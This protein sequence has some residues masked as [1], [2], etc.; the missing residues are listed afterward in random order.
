[1]NNREKLQK[2]SIRKYTVGTFSTVIATLVF[3]G[4]N[5]SHAQAD[6]LSETV[7]SPQQILHQKD[8]VNDDSKSN[9]N[10]SLANQ[11]DNDKTNEGTITSEQ[12]SKETTMSQ[13]DKES[14][15]NQITENVSTDTKNSIQTTDQTA[16][17]NHS[18]DLEQNNHTNDAVVNKAK[19]KLTAHVNNVKHSSIQQESELKQPAKINKDSLQA[20][21]DA[22]YHDYRFIDRDKVDQPTLDQVKNAFDKVNTLLGSNKPISDKSLQLAYQDLEQAVAT[23][24]T[25]PKRQ[26]QIRLDHQIQERAADSKSSDSY[27]SAITSYYVDNPNDGSG[28]PE[29]TYIYAA[30]KG[31]PFYLPNTPWIPL[32]ASDSKGIAYVTT[33]RL[34]DGYEWTIKFNQSHRMHEHMVFWFGLPDP[35]VP[36]GPVRFTIENPDNSNKVS[37][38]GVG[39]EEGLSL[40]FMWRTAGGIDSSRASNFVQG[41]RTGYTFYDEPTIHINSFKE[42]ARAPEFQHE[43]NASDDAKTNG[44]QNFALLNGEFPNQIYGIDRLYAF[45]GKGNASYTLQFKTQGSTAE[46]FYYAAGGRALEYRQLFS[47]NELYVE[48]LE[49]FTERV[50]NLTEVINRTYH[51][52]NSKNVYDLNAR[53]EVTKY[54]LDS[55]NENSEDFAS[56]PMSYAKKPS[57]YVGGFYNP[58]LPNNRFRGPGVAPLNEFEI[59]KLINNDTL[60]NAS[61]TGNPIKLNLGFDIQDG[62]GN[63]ETLMPVY[64]Y[65][66]PELQNNIGFFSNNNP[67]NRAELP[68]SKSAGHP[69]FNVFQGNMGNSYTSSG[70]TSNYV[71]PLRIQISSNEEFTDND[72]EITGV[73]SSLRI[74]NAAGRTNNNRER[75]LEL[76]GNIAPGDYLGTVRLRKKEQPFEIRVKPL[77]P[78]IDTTVR[79]LRGKGG[80]TPTITV[81]NVPAD[82][83][84]LVYLVV[85]GNLA[86]DGTNDPASVPRN[87]DIIASAAPSSTSNSVTFNQGDYVQNLP[88]TGVIRAIVY[89]NDNVISNFS[90]AVEIQADNTP[91]TIGNPLGLKNKYY[92]GDQV[93]FTIDITDGSNGTGIKSTNVSRLPQGWT[94][95]FVQ[96]ANGEGG[97]LRITG[98]V[99]DNQPFNSQIRFNV[100]ATDNNNNTTNNRQSKQIAINI[101]QMS[102]DFSPIVLPN[103]QKINVVNPGELTRT[104]ERDVINALKAVNTNIIPYLE[105]SSPINIPSTEMISF[106]YK[107]GS[108]D[109]ISISNAITYEPVRKAIYA[110]GNNTKEATVTIAR[111]QQFEFGDLKQYFALSNGADLPDSSLFTITAV[112]SLPNSAQ[113]SQLGVGTYTYRLNASDAYRQDQAPLTLKL[114]VVDVNQPTG[115]QRVY[116]ISTFNVTDDEK[117]QIK[118]AFIN[119]NRNQLQLTDNNIVITNTS[120]GTNTSTIT[121]NVIKDKLQK[122]FT[123]NATNMNFL[124]WVNFPNDYTV[125]WTSQTI[126]GRQTDGGFQWSQDHKS[127]IYRYDATS[128]RTI[129]ANDVLKLITANTTIPGLRTNIRGTEKALAEA[130]GTPS[131]NSVGY[132]LTAPDAAGQREFTYN[133][134]IIQ[135]LDLVETSHGYGGQPITYSN[136]SSN[137]TN[138]S[139]TNVNESAKNGVPAFTIDH[140][141]K[142]NTITGNNSPVYRAQLF[143]SPYGPPAYLQAI[144]SNQA[145]TTDVINVYF[146]P[147][148]SV[149]PT[150][151]LGNYNNHVV[152]SGESFTNSVAANDNYALGS[153]QV[154]PNSQVNG[155]VSNN[156]QTVTL[157]APNVTS[158]NDKT[159]TLVATDTSGNTT[160]QSFNV[161]VK[162]LK[163]KYRVTTN[164]TVGNPIR[165]ANI[166]DNAA[167][168]QA[169]QQKIIDS[170][171]TTNIAGTR[172]YATSGANEIRSKVVTGNVGRSNQ[173]PVATVTVTYADGSTSTVTVPVKHIIYNVVASPRYTIQGQDFPNGKGASPNDF[174]TLEN[175]DP[176]PDATITWL[177]NN[178]PN[179]NNTRIG[180]SI[181]VRANILFDGETTPIIKESSYMVVRTIPKQVFVTSRVTPIPGIDNPNNPKDYLKPINHSWDNNQQNMSFSFVG[182][183]SM[184]P[185]L[186]LVG[187]QTRVVRVT[188][189]NGQSENVR[190]LVNIRP[191][192]PRI[193]SNTVL[194]KAGLTNQDIKINNVLNQS[195]VTLFK[196]DGTPL[197][198]SN[199]TYG[200]GHSA[201]VVVSDA[202]PDGEIKAKTSLFTRNITY[203]TQN[204]QGQVQDVTQDITVDSFDS[205]PVR[206]TPQLHAIPDGAHFIKDDT[207][208]DFSSAARYIDQLPQGATAVWQDNADNWKN[209]VGNFT[210]TAVVTLPNGQG[211]RNVDIPVKI[212]PVAHAKAST[213]EVQGG[214]LSQGT[215]AINYITFDPNTNTN[216]ITA[217][218]ANQT[219]PS[220]S[221]PGVQNLTVNV[222]YPGVTTPVQV[223]VSLNVY[224]FNFSPNEYTTTI[225]TTFAR[226][227]E[228]SQYQHIVNNSGLPTE[229]FTYRWNQATTGTNGESWNALNKPS[230]AQVLNA[231]YDVLYNG[232]PFAT[233]QPARFII[234][235]VQ[236]SVPQ[237]SESKQGVITI[238][239]GANQSINTRTG[240][241]DTYADRLVIKHNGQVITTFVRNNSTSPWTKEASAQSVNGVVGSANGITIAPGTF[242]PSDNIQV[243][244]TQGNGELISD[245]QPSQMFTVVAPQPN[246]A[247]SHIWE[248]GQVEIAPNN[249]PTNLVNPTTALEITYIEQVGNTNEQTKTLQV[250]KGSNGQWSIADKPGY[251]TL[252]SATGK[253]TFNANTIKPNSDVTMISKAGTGNA[254]STNTNTYNIPN[255]HTV[256]INQIVKDFGTNVT[257]EDINNAVQA[258]NKHNATIKQG[259]PLP[260]N[261]AGGSTTTIPV[262][263]TYDDG[264]TEQITE[265]IFTKSDKRDLISAVNHL[266]DPISTDGKTPASITEFNN[267]MTNAQNEINTAMTQAEQVIQDQ[268]ASPEQVTQALNTVQAAQAKIDQAKALL[269]NKADNHELVQAKN[270]LQT[271]IDQQPSLDGMTQQSIDNYNAKRQAAQ[272]EITKAQQVIDNGDATPQQ[273]ATQKQNVEN[274]LNALN[275]A[276]SDLTADTSALQQAVQQL[277]RTGTTTGMRPASI[278]A[279]N[280]AMQ[281]LNPDLT[282]ARQNANAIINKPIRTVQEVQDALRQVNQVNE[283]ITQA[284]NQLQPLANNSELKTAKAKL[285]DE[286]NQTVSTDGMT[287]E[288]INAYQQAKQAAQTES[289]AAQQVINNGD[290]T[291]QDI[292]NEKAKVEDKY[293]ALKQTIA[294]LTP[295]VSPLE[296]AKV[297]LE[298]DINQATSTTGMTDQSVAN[299]NEKL[300]AA[301]QQLQEINQVLQSHPNV[302]TIRDYVAHANDA[303]SAL[304][305]ARNGLTVD[306][307]PLE[308]AKN[309]LQQSIDQATD[310]TGM[311]PDTINAYQAK[312]NAAKE[313]LSTINQVLNSNPTVDQINTNTTAANDA[314]TEL[315]DARS[316]LTPDQAPL[317]QAKIE[318]QDAINEAQSTDTTGMTQDSINALNE[319]LNAAKEN[320][321]EID[322]VLNNHPTVAQINDSVNQ[323]TNTKD[324]LNEARQNLVP[325]KA[326]LEAAKNALQQSINQPTNTTGMTQSSVDAYNEKLEQAKAKLASITQVL[327]GSPSVADINS[328]TNEAN[329]AKDALNQARQQLTVDKAPL[330]QAKTELEQSINQPTD[331]NGMTQESVAN[332][333]DKLNVAREKLREIEQVLNGNPTVDDINANTNAANNVTNALNQA[334]QQLTVD[335]A[336]LEAAKDALQQSINTAN[337]TDTNGMTQD[338]INTFNDKL[339]AAKEKLEAIKQVL[340]GNPTVQDI[341]TNVAQANSVKSDLDQAQSHLTPDKAPLEAAKNS[342]EASINQPTDTDGMTAAS[343]EAYHQELGKARQTLNESNQ[344]IAGQPT[345]AEIKA[346]VAQAQT[347]EADLNQAR[348]NL[349]LDRQPTLTTLQNATSLNDAQRN[350]LEEQ[351]NAAPNHA[352]L[353]ALQNDINQLNNAMT[354]LRDSIADNDQIKTGINYIDATPSIKSSYDNAVDDA[355]GTIDSQTQPITDP[356]TINQQAEAV[357]SSQA[358]LDGQQNL[359]R[360]KDEATATIVGAS[361]LN[362]AQKNALIQQ[363]SKAQNVQQANDI[364]QNADD[365]NNTMTALKQGIANHDQLI[366]SDNYVNA[367]PELKTAYNNKYD[368]AKAIV[369]GTGQSPILTSNEVNHA[370]K[371]VTFAA[372][373]LN[374]NTNLNNAKQQALTALGQLTHL[375]QAQRQALETQINDAHQ[376]DTV[377]NAKELA[378]NIDGAMANLQ[379][380]V[381]NKEDVKQG[382]DYIDAEQQKQLNYNDAVTNAE[383]IIN[384]TSQPTLDVNTI[385]QATNNV[386]QTK[387]A[388]D[389]EERLDQAKTAATTALDGLSHLNQAQKASLTDNINHA[390]RIADIEQLTQTA[391]DLNQ[392]MSDLQNGINNETTVLNSQ[393]YQ[394]ASPDNKANYTTAV[395]AAKDILNQAG[396]NKNKAQVEEALRQV[397]NAE[398]ALNGTQNLEQAKQDAKQQ[399]NSLT[400]LTDA[401]KAQLTHD[402]DHGQTVSDV[403]SIQNNA[404]TLNQAMDTLR[405]S[406]ADQTTVKDNEDYHDASP[407]QQQAY[408]SAVTDAENIINAATNPEMNA[409][410]INS[411]AQQVI[412]AKTKLNGDENLEA[413]KQDAKQYLD[414]LGQ[415]TDQQKA[416]L[417]N[418]ISQ[419]P[420]ISDVNQVKQMAN[421]LNQAMQQLQ[422]EVNQAP[423]VKTTENYTDADQSKQSDYD[424][425]VTTAE[426]ILDQTNGPNTSQDKVEEALQRIVAAKKALNGDQKLND[427][428]TNAQQYLGTLTHL[429]DAQRQAFETNINQANH[430]ADVNQIKQEAQ[431]LDGAMDQLNTLVN[432]QPSVQA[433]QNYLDA[434]QS[435]QSDYDM[436]LDTAQGIVNQQSGPNTPMNEV[437]NLINQI[438]QAQQALNGELNLEDAKRNATNTI[439]NSPDLNDAQKDALKAQV[440]N[441]KRV[442]DV[443]AI[444]QLAT[445]LNNNMTSLKEAIADKNDTLTSGNYINASD[446]K[447]QAYTN[448]VDNAEAI[449][450]GA[451]GAVLIPSEISNATSQVNAAKQDLNGDENLREAKQ[452][453]T[454]AV[455]GLASLNDAQRDQLKQQISQAQTLPDIATTQNKATVLNDAMHTLRDSIANASNIKTS[456][457]YT[458][459]NQNLQDAYNSQVDNANGIINPIATPTMDP[460]AITQAATQ[461]TTAEKALNGTENLRHAQQDALTH[462]DNLSHLTDAQKADFTQQINQATHVS[463]VTATQN[464]ANDLNTAMDQLNQ[465]IANQQAIKQSVNYTDANTNLKEDYSNAI[466]E[467]QQIL[468]KAHGPNT[469]QTDVVAAMQKVQ[470]AEQALNGN[471]NVEHAKTQALADLEHLTS[472]N[473]AQKE[474]LTQQINDATTVADVNQQSDKATELNTAMVQLQDG[475][476]NKQQTLDS[477]NYIDAE[478]SKQQAYN[479]AVSTAEQLLDKEHG[480]NLDKDAVAQALAQVTSTK[481]ALDGT[482]ILEQAK[483]NATNAIN[484]LQ[485]LT[486]LQKDELKRQIQQ[487]QNVANVDN[488]KTQSQTLDQAMEALRQSIQDNPSIKTGQNYL[489]ASNSNQNDYNTAIDQA[490]AII[491]ATSQPNMSA[492]EINQA[493]TKVNETKAALNGAQNLIQAKETAKH[494]I[495]QMNHLNQNQINALNDQVQQAN[496]IAAVNALKDS[497]TSLNTVMGQLK[498]TIAN[499]ND[500]QQS[501]NYTDA[502]TDKQQAYDNAVTQ[503]EAITDPTNGTNATQSQ[504]EAAIAKVKAAQQDLNGNRKVEEAKATAKQALSTYANL[505]HAQVNTATQ[506]INDAQTLEAVTQAQQE[507]NTL[508]NAMGQLQQGIAH[509][510]DVEQSVDYTDADTDKQQAYTDAVTQ[511]QSILD[512]DHGN[513]LTQSQVEQALANVNQ[514]QHDLNG[515]EKVQ[516]A[517]TAAIQDLGTYSNLNHAQTNTAQDRINNAQ[518]LA[519]VAQAKQTAQNL[520]HAMR[521]L[522]QSI[523]NYQDVEQSVDY[524]DADTNKQSA[525]SNAVHQ[526]QNTLDKDLGHDLT[527]SEVEQAIENVNHAKQ[528]LNGEEKVSEAKTDALQTLNNDTQ[529]N[530]HQREAAKNEINGA[531]TL[532]QVAQALDQATALNTAMGQLKDSISDQASIKQQINYTDADTD[533]KTNYDDAVTNAQVILDPV[534]GNNLSKEQVESAI[535]QVNT[536]KDQLNGDTNLQNAKNEA[537]TQLNAL[538]HINHAQSDNLRDQIATAPSVQAVH[539]IEATAQALDQAMQQLQQSIANRNDI[540]NSQNYADASPDKK[541]AYDQALQNADDI[542]AKTT[543]PNSNQQAVEQAMQAVTNAA[544]EL[545]GA[546]NLHDAQSQATQAI[547]NAPH[548]NEQQKM[549]LKKKVNQAQTVAA[550]TDLQNN[551]DALNTA[552]EQLKQAIADHDTIV[553]DGNYTNASPQEQG[554][555]TDAYQRAQNLINGTPDVIINPADITTATQNVN[556]AEQGLNGNT[557][558]A[559]AKQEATN[560]LQQM[561]GLSDAQR[562]SIQDQI[563]TA[564]QLPDVDKIK[565]NAGNLN[566]AMSDLRQEVAKQ[567]DVQASQ[568]YVDANTSNQDDYNHAITNAESMI[569]E[570]TQPTL[571][572]EAVTQALNQIKTSTQDLNGVENLNNAKQIATNDLQHL[573]HLNQAQQA[574][575]TQQLKDAPNVA[576]VEQ[577]KAKATSLDQ[578]MEQLINA[579]NDKDQVHQ[580]VN[581]SDAD[582]PKQSAYD[583]A[584]ND[585]QL[586]TDPTTGSNSSQAEVEVALSAINTAKQDLNGNRKVEDAKNN[587]N[588]ALHSL[589]HLNNAQR[590][591]IEHQ[592]DQAQTLADIDRI[593]NDAQALNN[594]MEQLAD[595]LN[596]K[597]E[598]L[599][600]QNYNDA[601]PDKKTD[602][603]DAVSNAET[604]LNPTQGGNLTKDEVEAAINAVN[605]K[606]KRP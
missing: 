58:S 356:T 121:V 400:S 112:N 13:T 85:T 30:N 566:N 533:R 202:L 421:D 254:E 407:D 42:F 50:K 428:K 256:T 447:R 233:S 520:N 529:L 98:I 603:T 108:T 375:N 600:S 402:I 363:V 316:N 549:N 29:G 287:T 394:D 548:L 355:K 457:N 150:L 429:T 113:V 46:R 251:V 374:G 236:P 456:Q 517:K 445:E 474:A 436:Y 156:N 605:S 485:N 166:R 249:T 56:D 261:L 205:D 313:K 173:S 174:F 282:Q 546:Q 494:D 604:I 377:N 466:Q 515:D 340:N 378:T 237:I 59:Y 354:K 223:P 602:Y 366:Q 238:A 268:F 276:K 72:W 110:E 32:R 151:S 329:I 455:D 357:K 9:I 92:K 493:A 137:K 362:Q 305:T 302:A 409:D 586:I 227:I 200:P 277:D 391:N 65:V 516:E 6:E 242:S 398:Q 504:V 265:T 498:D 209:N 396:P 328:N 274:A 585:A 572:P 285:D 599:N 426:A 235:N 294:N 532:S 525:Y 138:S 211:T 179:K 160:N 597:A 26:S 433:T 241:I 502:D 339:N 379:Q 148:D 469:S 75:N 422:A 107:D 25:L 314:K 310:T 434:D 562:Q 461:V 103:V 203:T 273:I 552:M 224:Q 480:Q 304:D 217:D 263:I 296:R 381:A 496:D 459:A 95:Q 159:I 152:Y 186:H 343:L 437:Q 441:G 554:A 508:N 527:Q 73:P 497:A 104:E 243:I 267:A 38:L 479:Q 281:A 55:N 131:Y 21:F 538:D 172:P 126:P 145:N 414:T 259:T 47:Y 283:R 290:A 193:D 448:Q 33:K 219:L 89:Y 592:I 408:N 258:L 397:Q 182:S 590:E 43:Q 194:F 514:A 122:S 218:W 163:D 143:L 342:L 8:E 57:R 97:T 220:T 178:T 371:Q 199:T 231:K 11:L 15:D 266:D 330:Q 453:A 365:L 171:T 106:N 506:H 579:V 373:A 593:N 195:P 369:E 372:Q 165:I 594:A 315:D 509:H 574:D 526:A 524:T 575:L 425:S 415:I 83:N 27:Q 584:I 62:Y 135:A 298:N 36:V 225:G 382:E 345:V 347:N 3:L 578:A 587:A 288:S 452:N 146:V 312:L 420:H 214:Q 595:S 317:Q 18:N 555:Y 306:K 513:D 537:N 311:T 463:D 309:A 440:S 385:N 353:V 380:S 320:I 352:A 491:D 364:K 547:E 86:Q 64:L 573:S 40:P 180:E 54:I 284:I 128:G 349:T 71:Q 332:Y 507:A 484:D 591:N 197:A 406:I 560:A 74:E 67:N 331:T 158:S 94:S 465:A 234:R 577:V 335:K 39:T 431:S 133:G 204:N 130:G 248:N 601:S 505:N 153:V 61:R 341:N 120:N 326:P 557:N 198:I 534:N 228:A 80:T 157:H 370:L 450:N 384:E 553:A 101:G 271:S 22:N 438:N 105:N 581:Y 473:N 582:Q 141:I 286:I 323:A 322:R 383:T 60:T 541:Q 361:D 606:K 68:E 239:P 84:A 125:G 337:N 255:A 124:R 201:T 149:N 458:D 522:Q 551:A 31:K 319:K 155:T 116:R 79:E 1:M 511:A 240:N 545:N 4:F 190:F 580:S 523:D 250:V 70:N 542:L 24:R 359:Q 78:Q 7:T 213:R 118:Q 269:Q 88:N 483:T 543:G 558:L 569:N 215:E 99:S 44:E 439:N 222:T 528:E 230:S 168:S 512:K 17:S 544:H 564:K 19:N 210:K 442:A 272:S 81:S 468:D 279:Y 390:N 170:V 500:V 293:N 134:K 346:K 82:P 327:N 119:A 460:D 100:S 388:L 336:P 191:D 419:S 192:P 386:N 472:L 565:A 563:D 567:H 187:S 216:G 299:Y 41:P 76:V 297:D 185:N 324:A 368:Q 451:Q 123:S 399:L 334:R 244:A 208:N 338:S 52:G 559:N 486:N 470:T 169:D 583:H 401:Q 102:N 477:Q 181:T 376:I 66:K 139:L 392:A 109:R 550:V 416:N 5:A 490:N 264:S 161:T 301:K 2:F 499:H 10:T 154:A 454:I 93:N 570:A 535:N 132:S 300:N 410:A 530:Q 49:H 411:K 48:P 351:I 488:V 521:Q 464:S 367:N 246:Q 531:T 489:D 292:A 114:K 270:D 221:Q 260:V 556:N 598:T 45:I 129:N 252:D 53:R 413:A 471:Q 395:Q 344:L 478:P 77:P 325:D 253:V 115:D 295:D 449:I 28:Y 275:Q 435:K 403:Q 69:V 539:Q 501:V 495:G 417:I 589:N 561:T 14:A 140:V 568:P 462:L 147:S 142:N 503:A 278:T 318:L 518:T 127:L 424:Q 404:D 423:Q 188:Y 446:D 96:N 482:Q 212:Y 87:Y 444:E 177:P 430:I 540:L 12:P 257:P 393:N 226:G 162:P 144:N 35:Q 427:T 196:T 184:P 443:K 360:A 16:N 90:N 207:Q 492:T 183:G 229:G 34:K 475:I 576:S 37:S 63:D 387:D 519:E 232:Q 262:V 536:T 206:V 91:P 167:I 481:D 405:Q 189:A 571:N 247:T 588:Q 348:S 23:L 596:D 432:N 321:K 307:T 117:A 308:N 291:E 245:E 412:S 510:Q 176:V 111:G 487:A 303:K 280:Q 333:N 164:A 418:Q 51:L 358:A 20:F 389:G 175:G 476:A 289:E 136:L 467:A 350:R